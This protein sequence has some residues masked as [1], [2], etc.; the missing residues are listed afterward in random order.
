LE[1]E[2]I[3]LQAAL[4]EEIDVDLVEAISSLTARQ[5]AF[6]A[7]LRVIGQIFRL[8]LLDFL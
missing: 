5:A 4:S 6:E 1:D 2:L 7:S 3:E 8:S